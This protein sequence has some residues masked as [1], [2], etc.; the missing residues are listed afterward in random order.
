MA[1]EVKILSVFVAI[2]LVFTTILSTANVYATEYV[3]SAVS[4]G[5]RYSQEIDLHGYDVYKV[6]VP[7]TMNVNLRVVDF[8]V[9]EHVGLYNGGF[10][11]VIYDDS[12]NEISSFRMSSNRVYT[13]MLPEGTYYY[14]LENKTNHAINYTVELYY[15]IAT[16]E[17]TIKSLNKN[18]I[19]VQAKKGS[20]SIHGYEVRYRLSGEKWTTKKIEEIDNLSIKLKK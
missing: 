18:T 2:S 19:D 7:A 6:V 20:D 3:E 14:N 10:D 13:T 12:Y 8:Y 5:E 17:V 11:C 16:P 15:S 4:W 1:R 9:G